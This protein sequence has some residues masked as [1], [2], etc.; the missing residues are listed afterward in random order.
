MAYGQVVAQLTSLSVNDRQVLKLEFDK[1]NADLAAIRTAVTGIT[2]KLD[3]E[4]VT[5]LD[6]DYASLH[7][8]AALTF[9]E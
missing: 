1:I 3:A 6:T 8:P 9:T 7:D 5:N 4:N 2:A